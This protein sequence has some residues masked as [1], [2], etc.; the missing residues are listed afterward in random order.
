M[1]GGALKNRQLVDCDGER[2]TFTSR[3]HRDASSGGSLQRRMTIP[4]EE[5]L[6]RVLQ[7]VVPVK[8][9]VV[10]FYGLY[11]ASKAD[12][13]AR[14]RAELGQAPAVREERAPW[15]TVCARQGDWH[16]ERCPVCG[17]WLVCTGTVPRRVG[18]GPPA[19]ARGRAA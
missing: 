8:T 14:V 9:Q 16:P 3:D 5:F 13:L 4:G 12:A 6:R 17:A 2:V 18:V 1:R 19:V 7:H 11:H 10:R 15:Q